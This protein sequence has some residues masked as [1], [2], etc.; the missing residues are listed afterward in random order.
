M[1]W[2]KQGAWLCLV[3]C[4]F[5]MAQVRTMPAPG[6]QETK[7]QEVRPTTGFDKASAEAALA[8]GGSTIEGIACAYHD[9]NG[10]YTKPKPFLARRQKVMLFPATPYYDE[11]FALLRKPGRVGKVKMSD[12]ALN[13]R[14]DAETDD[15]GVFRFTDMRPGSYHLYMA[16]SFN[17][18]ASRNVYAGTSTTGYGDVDHYENQKYLIPRADLLLGDVEIKTDG[19]TVKTAMVGG[20]KAGWL[21]KMLPCK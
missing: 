3:V 17:Q 10:G 2:Y 12:E 21:G 1:R 20:E 9:T 8:K 5:A 19:T 14:I 13:T 16:M 6:E 18:A 11:V 4:G 15:N 7:V